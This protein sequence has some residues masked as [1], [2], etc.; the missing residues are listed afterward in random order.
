MAGGDMAQDSGSPQ[1]EHLEGLSAR[2]GLSL[3]DVEAFVAA[4]ER[5]GRPGTLEDFL[6]FVPEQRS[7]SESDQRRHA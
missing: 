1:Q 2:T 7:A 4:W 3:R 6:G 5:A